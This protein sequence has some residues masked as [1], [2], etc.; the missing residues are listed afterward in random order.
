MEY[1]LWWIVCIIVGAVIGQF[2]GNR[3]RGFL[4]GLV[5]GPIGVIV[6]LLA[7]AYRRPCPVCKKQIWKSAHE[8]PHCHRDVAPERTGTSTV[9][10]K[11]EQREVQEH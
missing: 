11:P 7:G 4:L 3:F 9:D 5:L 8:C 10:P 6:E 2:H 1:F